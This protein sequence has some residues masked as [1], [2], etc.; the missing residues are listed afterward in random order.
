MEVMRRQNSSCDPCRRSKRRCTF[1]GPEKLVDGA[2]CNNCAHL[3]HVCTFN[4]VLS[5][6]APKRRAKT[7]TANAPGRPPT[8]RN[9]C[10]EDS[11]PNDVVSPTTSPDYQLE[12]PINIAHESW[13]DPVLADC[14]DSGV[15]SLNCDGELPNFF[16]S[17][18]LDTSLM[19]STQL[20]ED[21]CSLPARV[22]PAAPLPKRHRQSFVGL[23]PGSPV[24]LLNS[25]LA[26]NTLNEHLN[27]T[28]N[29][30]LEGAASRF[31]AYRCNMFE[32]RYP[33]Y[34]EM[35]CPSS[36]LPR[37]PVDPDIN[38]FVE[39]TSPQ[40]PNSVDP[41][42]ASAFPSFFQDARADEHRAAA[43][44]TPP[45]DFAC[46]VTTLGVVRFL[47]NFSDLYGNRLDSSAHHLADAAL[48][49]VL[50]A[51]STQWL[52]SSSDSDLNLRTMSCTTSGQSAPQSSG[53]AI[54]HS[55]WFKARSCLL[56][57][58][59][60][61]IFRVVYA[62]FLFD[63]TVIPVEAS[64]SLGEDVKAHE[65]L[66]CSLRHLLDLGELVQNWCR[67]LGPTSIYA[68]LIEF[69]LNIMRWFGY[70]RD[71]VASLTSDRPLVLP[72]VPNRSKST[73]TSTAN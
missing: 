65:F 37:P 71:T 50:Q 20:Q 70:V 42:S 6:S 49:A 27:K 13:S 19:A 58:R 22:P 46:K 39:T 61:R 24:H 59:S 2:I 51:F 18:A 66:N 16:A 15:L 67:T 25:S 4:F 63:M 17:P 62:I 30:I 68:T 33:Y 52:P 53:S 28:Y 29:T 14:F 26:V 5:R 3:G 57:A 72:D 56:K 73:L 10:F 54:F 40:R 9:T 7:R 43:V 12:E 31:L 45:Q 55:A 48:E 1:R 34:F 23:L 69:S 35:E 11:E 21:P 32:D 38:I 41:K 47:D 8:Q 64:S 44:L 36:V 60:V